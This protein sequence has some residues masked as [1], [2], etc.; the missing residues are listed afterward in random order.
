MCQLV[1]QLTMIWNTNMDVVNLVSCAIGRCLDTLCLLLDLIIWTVNW[2][3]R[4]LSNMGSYLH[5]IPVV[6]SGTTLLEYWNFA[7]FSF[8]TVTEVVTST[9]HGALHIL[10]GWIQTLGGVV[11]S[12]KMV[13]H[14]SAHV[15]WRAKE[16]LQRGLI[17]G[18]FVLK[19][20]CEGF[21]IAFSLVF[22]FVNTIVNIV[23]IGTQNCFSAVV[24]A[25][26]AVSGPLHKALELALTLLT[27]LYSCLVGTSVL[28]WTPFQLV[29]EFL[30][31]LGHVFITV[32]MLNIYG[33]LLTA[34][35][36]A[37]TWLYLNPRLPRL[38]AQQCVHF[39]NSLPGMRIL[40]RA[41]YRLYLLAL[42]RAQDLHDNNAGEPTMG[43]RVQAGNQRGRTAQPSGSESGGG[44]PFLDSRPP[45]SSTDHT[46]IPQPPEQNG[47]NHSEVDLP[48]LHLSSRLHE[49][50]FDL[51]HSSTATRNTL[52]QLPGE[53]PVISAPPA[54]SL[55]SLLKEHEERKKCVICQD[56]AK[57]V[58][59]LP[60]RHLCLCRH[61]SAILLQQPPQQHCCPLCRRGITQTMDVFL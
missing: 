49:T 43:H 59:L 4:V 27:F 14:L 47:R 28:L 35:I 50:N 30:G 15:V 61:C 1:R 45:S 23:L 57:N 16:L 17:S 56:Q 51:E 38:A 42:E 54:D 19:Q 41:A 20:T 5:N 36:V 25:W 18:N 21:C 44:H 11:E 3:A 58:L 26:E 37:L 34:G 7:L 29:L 24:G 32:F 39:V 33:L 10:E 8:L 2:L 12:F 48:R 52:K 55:L 46:N 53:E 6:L 22:Y 31:S 9:A 40:Q 60:C 13:G